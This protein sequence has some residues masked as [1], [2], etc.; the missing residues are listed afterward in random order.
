MPIQTDRKKA[1]MMKVALLCLVAEAA[2][3]TVWNPLGNLMGGDSCT[4]S[5]D[6]PMPAGGDSLCYQGDAVVIGVCHN[7]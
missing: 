3:F 7:S 2:A 4:G 6:P 1:N 5:Q